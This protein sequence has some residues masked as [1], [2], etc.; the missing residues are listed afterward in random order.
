MTDDRWIRRFH[1]A[2]PGAPRL[3]CFP[4]AGGSASYFFPVSAALQPAVEVLA[5]QYP[6]RHDRRLEPVLTDVTELADL[7]AAALR[8]EPP[9]RTTFFGHSMG[10][11][12]GYEV[13]RRL[14]GHGTVLG[15]LYVS[16]RRAPGGPRPGDDI[17]TRDDDGILAELALLGGPGVG[18][19]ADPE[20]RELAMP[21]LRGDH[22]AIETYSYASG[23]LLSCPVTALLGDRDPKVTV[24]EAREWAGHTSGPFDLRVFPGDHFYLAD[25]IPDVLATIRESIPA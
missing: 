6:G 12:V 11:I 24:A 19:L 2:V 4:Y 25:Q 8:A 15:H 1:P 17:H 21:A 9:A 22:A 3:V 10:A 20:M 5:V 18:L 7:I 13:A 14:E 16:G 23:A